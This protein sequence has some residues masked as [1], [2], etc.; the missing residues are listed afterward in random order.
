MTNRTKNYG[1]YQYPE[2]QIPLMILN[3]LE[4]KSLPIYEDGQQIREWIHV[5]DHC[6]A[7]YLV[8]KRGVSGQ[9]YNIR[10]ENH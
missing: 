8:L 5:E 4:G 10:G 2:K 1:P 9:C 7:I 3:A 6:E